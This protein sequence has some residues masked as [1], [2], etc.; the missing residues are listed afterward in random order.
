MLDDTGRKL[1]EARSHALRQADMAVHQA[2]VARAEEARQQVEDERADYA[3][4]YA[5]REARRRACKRRD[6]VRC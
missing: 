3:A 6:H 5:D 4:A 1:F 2:R